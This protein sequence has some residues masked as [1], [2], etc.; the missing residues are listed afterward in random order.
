MD[1]NNE[2][3]S[4]ILKIRSEIKQIVKRT[5][6][7]VFEATEVHT[8]TCFVLLPY[9]VNAEDKPRE[10]LEEAQDFVENLSEI[11]EKTFEPGGFL[12]NM[13][14]K[15]MDLVVGKRER[16]YL[17]LIDEYTGKATLVIKVASERMKEWAPVMMVGWK[18]IFLLNSTAAVASMFFPGIP[19]LNNDVLKIIGN[20]INNIS[21]SGSGLIDKVMKDS[22]DVKNV[23][24]AE[25][26]DFSQ[27][28]LKEDKEKTFADLCR[29]CDYE[30]GNAIW[31]TEASKEA[32][33]ENVQDNSGLAQPEKYQLMQQNK[34]LVQ[35]KVKWTEEKI[36]LE[37]KNNAL[38]EE[39]MK[40]RFIFN[41]LRDNHQA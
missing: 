21:T 3:Q 29:V 19:S 9:Q 22:N 31:V 30:S 33:R 23:R 32:L 6:N 26:R 37:Q 17:Y 34:R 12:K 11:I 25:L 7:A 24:G 13:S 28:L 16:M 8:P 5:M 2:I 39:K 40:R 20:K 18:S 15:I 1:E 35:E 10:F 36:A 41:C 14:E 27:Y 4:K 38:L